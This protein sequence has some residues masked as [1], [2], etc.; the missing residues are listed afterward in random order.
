MFELMRESVFNS[1]LLA[2]GDFRPTP[3][4]ADI[5]KTKTKP[6]PKRVN[7]PSDILICE[8]NPLPLLRLVIND[9]VLYL[10]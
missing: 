9:M 5:T 1:V 3:P 8:S 10:F 2:L 6:T 7:T 4:T